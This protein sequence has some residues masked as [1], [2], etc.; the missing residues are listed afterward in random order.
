M[1]WK[2]CGEYPLATFESYASIQTRDSKHPSLD[3]LPCLALPRLSLRF[4]QLR[5]TTVSTLIVR[6]AAVIPIATTWAH[7]SMSPATGWIRNVN[8]LM[9]LN[10]LAMSF[11]LRK[12]PTLHLTS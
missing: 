6:S 3:D 7:A 12:I 2:D 8:A 5:M 4:S 1:G 11:D 9:G 10:I